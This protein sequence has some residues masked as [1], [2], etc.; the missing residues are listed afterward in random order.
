[1]RVLSPRME[2]P[3]TVDEGST[4]STATRCPRS[5]RY[6]PNDSMNVLL[7][8]PGTPLT[9]MRSAC[10]VRGSKAVSNSSPWARWSAR[11]DSSSVIAL[12]VARRR[13]IASPCTMPWSRSV[14]HGLHQHARKFSTTRADA[15]P[16]RHLLRCRFRLH[17]G[18]NALEADQKDLG[19]HKTGK[20]RQAATAFLI[21]SSTS[22]A[23]AGIGV[24]G[25]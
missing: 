21:C 23:Q 15:H 9:P 11:V 1:M 4:A 3:E 14:I 24:P 2:P 6:T 5:I 25:P 12:A 17:I 8:T 10:P 22:L 13:R 16:H 19:V 7:P 20:P 18:Q